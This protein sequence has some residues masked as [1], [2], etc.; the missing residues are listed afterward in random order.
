MQKV[1]FHTLGCKR[2]FAESAAISRLLTEKGFIAV[3]LTQRPHVFVLN[4]CSVTENADHKCAKVIRSAL[5][6]VPHAFVIVIGCS[7]HN[8]IQTLLRVSQ[9]R[10]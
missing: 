1:A 3:A 10:C 7:T 6:I 2:N 9:A 4:T 5:K 8:W